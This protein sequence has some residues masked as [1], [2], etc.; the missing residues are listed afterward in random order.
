MH[1]R[2]TAVA[3]TFYPASAAALERDL[4]RFVPDVSE[5]IE[6]KGV[7]APHAGYIYSGAVA[8]EVYAAVRIPRR[9]IILCPNHSGLGATLAFMGEGSWETPLG[10]VP[11]DEET[12]YALQE[13]FPDLKFDALAHSREHSL[14]VHLPF[15]RYLQPDLTFVPI[16]LGTGRLPI[17][18]ELGDALADTVHRSGEPVLLVASSDMSHFEPDEISRKK[19]S[20]A[21][22]EMKALNPEGLHEVVNRESISMCGYAAAVAVM[23]A[24][25]Q[26]GATRGELVRY[27]TSGDVSGDYSSVV[28]YASLYFV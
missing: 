12:A 25:R 3:G 20:L 23:Q 11:L 22:A 26:L 4:Q 6:V 21:I 18:L 13:R 16:C 5:K 14:E 9:V 15:L 2:R 27:A 17:L 24:C 19:D 1:I 28:G 7:V 10:E 8:G